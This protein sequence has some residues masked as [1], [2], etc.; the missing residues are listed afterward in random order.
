[1]GNQSPNK[2]NGYQLSTDWVGYGVDYNHGL[3]RIVAM[4]IIANWCTVWSKDKDATRGSW[5]YY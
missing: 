3:K 4:L 5:P 2:V 1:M